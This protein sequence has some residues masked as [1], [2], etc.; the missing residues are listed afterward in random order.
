[1]DNPIPAKVRSVLYILGMIVGGL[2]AVVLPDLLVAL[3]V[4]EAWTAV[5]TRAAGATTL[6]LAT[7]AQANL[8][9]DQ[10]RVE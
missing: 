6:L 10:P 4:D 1:M 8:S 7:L 3:N 2:V 5:A 9:P